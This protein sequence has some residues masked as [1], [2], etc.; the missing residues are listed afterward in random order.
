MRP[1]G[2]VISWLCQ[3][4]AENLRSVRLAD[5]GKAG[6]D[7]LF[8]LVLYKDGFRRKNNVG[9]KAGHYYAA[10]IFRKETHD[11]TCQ[12]DLR[13]HSRFAAA[14]KHCKL[15]EFV[16]HFLEGFGLFKAGGKM[17][18]ILPCKSAAFFY[19]LQVALYYC[20]RCA[21]VMSDI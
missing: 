17:A 3:S 19:K 7:S 8:G 14:F 18:F 4:S 21:Q 20:K 11:K 15:K 13:E 6:I 16:G 12:V 5:Y 9:F 1:A 2:L 10:L